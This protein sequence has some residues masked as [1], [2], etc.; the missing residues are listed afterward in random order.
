MDIQYHN[1]PIIF[2]KDFKKFCYDYTIVPVLCTLGEVV[3]VF[4]KFQIEAKPVINYQ[5]FV[6]CLLSFA[7]TGNFFNL[8]LNSYFSQDLERKV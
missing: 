1:K 2:F 6:S 8:F 5:G 4:K 3:E 7:N